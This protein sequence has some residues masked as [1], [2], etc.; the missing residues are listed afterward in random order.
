MTGVA[1]PVTARAFLFGD[2][3]DAVATLADV[4]TSGRVGSAIGGALQPLAQATRATAIRELS[5]VASGLFDFDIT[6]LLVTGWR[7]H[8]ILTQAA[9]RTIAAPGS[10][11]RIDL[12]THRISV[13]HH[14]YVDLIVDDVRVTTVDFDLQLDFD[15]KALS[16]VVRSGK[17][18]E[19]ATGRCDITGTLAIERVNALTRTA[20]FDLR[21]LIRLDRGIPL[22][23]SGQPTAAAGGPRAAGAAAV[24]G[25]M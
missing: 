13:A 6:D 19:I 25:L 15:V 3:G 9:R 8:S 4:L 5:R 24:P 18:V 2:E 16:A 22:L 14:P 11:E 7:K 12:A 10:E 21:L 1:G 20:Q 17:L 23:P